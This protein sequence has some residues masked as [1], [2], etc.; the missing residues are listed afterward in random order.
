M[1]REMQELYSLQPR[2]VTAKKLNAGKMNADLR[3]RGHLTTANRA[4]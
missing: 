1:G 4:P 3:L 2:F